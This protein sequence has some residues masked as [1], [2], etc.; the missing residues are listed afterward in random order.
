[1]RLLIAAACRL[2]IVLIPFSAS[3]LGL[4][5]IE[6]DS[7]LNQPFLAEIPLESVDASELT[8]LQVTLA[9]RATFERYGLDL[10]EFLKELQFAVKTDSNGRS[11]IEL[12]SPGPVA[13][14]FVSMLLDVKWASG[15]LLREYTVLL[16]PPLFEEQPVQQAVTP[17]ETAPITPTESAG[18]VDRPV[19]V[20]GETIAPTGLFQESAEPATTPRAEAP[21]PVQPEPVATPAPEPMVSA[22]LQASDYLTQRGDTLWRIAERARANAGISNN[23]MMLA[24]YRS[25]PEA[26]L[27][28]INRLKAGTILRIPE[29]ADASAV[30]SSEATAEVRQQ[31]ATWNERSAQ[32]EEARLELVAPGDDITSGTD[33]ASAA[34]DSD[35]VARAAQ[36]D[37]LQTQVGD[38]EAQLDESQRLLQVRDAELQALQQRIAELE[39]QGAEVVPEGA[40]PAD[41]AE[42]GDLLADPGNIFADEAEVADEEAIAVPDTGV[43]ELLAEPEDVTT[44]VTI[45]EEEPSFLGG[46][47]A[48]VWLWVGAAV[49]LLLGLFIAKR[50]R[51]VAEG[52]DWDSSLDDI[53]A[54]AGED[55]G[56]KSFADLPALDDSIVVEE[57]TEDIFTGADEDADEVPTVA[58][59]EFEEEEQLAETAED[60]ADE[61]VAEDL[62]DDFDGETSDEDIDIA[63][64][65]IKADVDELAEPT[66][67]L[68]E[69]D[70]AAE[71]ADAEVEMPLEKTISTGAPLNLDQADPIAEA[72]FHMAYGLYDQA[73]DLLSRSLEDEPENRTYRVKLIEVFFVWENKEGFLEQAQLLHESVTED[74]DSDWSKVLILGKQLCPDEEIFAGGATITPTADSMDLELADAGETEIDFTLGGTEVQSL[75]MDLPESDDEAD[76]DVDLG[77]GIFGDSDEETAD[78]LTLDLGAD[79][80]EDTAESTTESPTVDLYGSDSPTVETDL[81]AST[82]ETPTVELPGPGDE[83]SASTM[84][85]PTLETEGPGGETSEMPALDV[86]AFEEGSDDEDDAGDD[87]VADPTS[88]DVDLGG[89]A[90]YEEDENPMSLDNVEDVE[91]L[92][93]EDATQFANPDDAETMLA[94]LDEDATVLASPD[95]LP[96]DID[97]TMKASDT[98]I[99]VEADSAAND[100]IEQPQVEDPSGDT[101]EQPAFSADIDTFESE[102]ESPGPDEATM[103]EVGTKLDLAR[104]Y[105]DMG[106][107]EGAR[108]ILNEVLDE[109]GDSQQ[110]EARQLLEELSD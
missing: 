54:D 51:D 29:M 60:E 92:G 7:A 28:N 93:E 36:T 66:T 11:Y 90:E 108:S 62:I 52:D 14:P 94:G 30:S 83:D 9:D 55:V 40:A 59:P 44:V 6:L 2:W 38:L 67:S 103:T 71:S 70:T 81:G 76:I 97:K 18:D 15:R 33:S 23:Q 27:G 26:F 102:D 17:A 48:N 37:Q 105:I 1:M 8:D 110:Q 88:L 43:E 58:E 21:P 96:A 72:E 106:D 79:E 31:Y 25:N 49:L 5:E 57:G 32:P 50:R 47:L 42:E 101:A 89:L 69:D 91:E 82:M 107:P 34:A 86:S 12:T 56:A 84:E 77:E 99:A 35:I 74:T 39:Q 109:G 20:Q 16:D 4:G 68:D 22:G 24:L 3:A 87:V 98:D 64:D 104:A 75:D 78:S 80:P 65:T 45:P 46:L 13:E 95:D 41:A 100:T 85:T 10:P 19:T 61:T 63:F 73:A 53:V